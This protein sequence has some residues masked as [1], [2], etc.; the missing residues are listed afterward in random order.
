MTVY[1][2]LWRYRTTHGNHNTGHLRV[3]KRRYG[4]SCW[5]ALTSKRYTYTGPCLSQYFHV[6]LESTLDPTALQPRRSFRQCERC[7]RIRSVSHGPKGRGEV[8]ETQRRG[9]SA[10]NR[11]H[12][13][14]RD[15]LCGYIKWVPAT[16]N[17]RLGSPIVLSFVAAPS[18][19]KYPY[20]LSISRRWAEISTEGIHT[21]RYAVESTYSRT[22]HSAVPITSR[23]LGPSL[24]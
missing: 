13:K 2:V 14:A 19:A 18:L 23:T 21:S 20:L 11:G 17:S 16:P 6:H 8:E 9:H 1:R 5:A 12:T 15:F 4:A 7:V 22:R 3:V 10:G 24:H